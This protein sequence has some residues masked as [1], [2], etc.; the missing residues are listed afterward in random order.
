MEIQNLRQAKAVWASKN[1]ERIASDDNLLG[2]GVGLKEVSGKFTEKLAVKYFVRIK[3][4]TGLTSEEK[5]PAKLQNVPTDV[6]QM[7]PLRAKGSLTLRLRPV[8]GGCSGCVVVPGLNYTG[9]FG[10]AMRGYGS[11]ADRT[12]VLSNNHVL[13]NENSSRIGDT[14]IQPGTLDGGDPAADVIGELY[15]FVPLQF[16][17]TTSVANPAVNKVDAACALVNEFGTFNREIFWIGYPRGWRTRESVEDAVASGSTR[18]QKTGRTTGY[19]TGTISAVSWDGW[20]AYDSGFAYFEDQI[21]IT[22]GTFSDSGDS[23][24]CILD[25]DENIIGLLFGG[26]ATHTIANFIEDVWKQLSP[27]D[28]SDGIV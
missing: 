26:G 10:L 17:A 20:I 11:L 27:I 28:F 16:E 19:T 23:G 1:K 8:F 5:L 9:T 15:D 12:F 13:A 25:M 21:L 24:S 3:K 2:I 18:V 6:V 4:K 7:A 22:P 14:V